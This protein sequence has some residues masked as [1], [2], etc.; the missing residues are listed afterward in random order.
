M[1]ASQMLYR[2]LGSPAVPGCGPCEPQ[3]CWVCGAP[4]AVGIHR[5][6]W[7]GANFVGQNRVRSQQSTYVCPA[8]IHCMSGRGLSGM[9]LTSHLYE[10]GVEYLKPNKADKPAMR[11]FLRRQ[12]TRPWFASVSDSGQK[13]L[14]P[15]TPVNPPG[16]RRPV[17]LFE[18]L[19]VTLPAGDPGWKLVDDMT[20][21]LT[22][23]A[24]KETIESGDYN[25]YAWQRCEAQLRAFEEE[26]GSKRSSPWFSLAL[27]LAQRDEAEVQARLEVEKA[28]RARAEKLTAVGKLV[29]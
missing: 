16:I 17:V 4:T 3:P 24:S 5:E 29:G 12:H 25:G 28:A 26:W 19:L 2:H 23:G 15:W 18:E 6:D 14:L 20:R 1:S 21:L 22:D 7:M 9:R 11:R 8:C 27:W 10:D 13:H